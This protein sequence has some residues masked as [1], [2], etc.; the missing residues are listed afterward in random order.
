VWSFSFLAELAK[1]LGPF[2]QV[3]TTEFLEVGCAPGRFLVY[4]HQ[5]YGWRV[6]GIELSEAGLAKTRAVLEVNGV[7]ARLYGGDVLTMEPEREYDVLGA[8]GLVE[9]FDDPVPCYRAM[10][11]WVRRGG[12]LVVTVPNLRGPLGRAMRYRNPEDY[13]GHRRFGPDDPS[14]PAA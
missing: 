12:A 10:A 3:R 13:A 2:P 1:H 9:H 11:R 5:V 14:P 8:F 7:A 4:F 6:A